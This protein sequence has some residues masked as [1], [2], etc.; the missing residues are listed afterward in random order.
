LL[1]AAINEHVVPCI[2]SVTPPH[3]LFKWYLT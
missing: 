2:S 3:C 1:E